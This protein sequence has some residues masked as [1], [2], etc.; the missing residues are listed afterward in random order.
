MSL[1]QLL[2]DEQVAMIHAAGAKN[3]R[4]AEGYR[5]QFGGLDD[6]ISSYV[7]RN[8]GLAV[9]HKPGAEIGP[10]ASLTIA[11][12]IEPDQLAGIDRWTEIWG[13]SRDQ[14]VQ[15]LIARGM[16]STSHLMR[17]S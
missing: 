15:C 17:S 7:F 8:R 16:G 10:Q 14:A 2:H 9:E 11:V 3:W 5:N 13:I 6:R 1:N 4:V 12:E